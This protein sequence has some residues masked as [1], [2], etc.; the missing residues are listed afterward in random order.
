MN[1]HAHTLK[2]DRECG[3]VDD[4]NFTFLFIK[5]VLFSPGFG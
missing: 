4:A 1:E 5:K 3:V 2:K